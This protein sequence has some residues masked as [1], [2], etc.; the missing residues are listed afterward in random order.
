MDRSVGHKQYVF[1]FE[2]GKTLKIYSVISKD[3]QNVHLF[4]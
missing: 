2:T 1:M 4:T 3:I